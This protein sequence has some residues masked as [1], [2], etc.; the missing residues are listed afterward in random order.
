MTEDNGSKPTN[1]P[2]PKGTKGGLKGRKRA[3]NEELQQRYEFVADLLVNHKT[4]A[5]IK[6]AC[7][8]E[9][10]VKT[11]SVQR[12][13]VR[14][15]EIIAAEDAEGT[16]PYKRARAIMF[17]EQLAADAS[18]SAPAR[19]A[20]RKQLDEIEGIKASVKIRAVD[21]DDNDILSAGSAMAMID[22]ISG[23]LVDEEAIDGDE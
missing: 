11:D 12:Y 8:E 5:E 23:S 9:F 7:W 3:T 21:K 18:L 6:R 13:I 22:A 4:K 14:A 10:R 15:R 20:A 2:L 16:M 19:I 17:Y 1:T